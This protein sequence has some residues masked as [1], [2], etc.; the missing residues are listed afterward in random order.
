MNSEEKSRAEWE[1][2]LDQLRTETRA[3]LAA[4]RQRG[5][6]RLT[7]VAGV[8]TAVMVAVNVAPV[9]AS[10]L[11][12]QTSDIANRAVTTKKLANRSVKPAKLANNAVRTAKIQNGA[13]LASKIAAGAVGTGHLANGAVTGPKLANRSVSSEKIARVVPGIA[14][15]GADISAN[16]VSI[17]NWFNRVGGVPVVTKNSTGDYSIAFPG[18]ESQVGIDS[19]VQVTIVGSGGFG[20]QGA[21]GSGI[22]RVF[23]Y[24][25]TGT[26]TDKDFNVTVVAPNSAH[27]TPAST[28]GVDSRG[29]GD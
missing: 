6:R 28:P 5:R 2:R 13:V 21:G 24:G 26:L 17:H 11:N 10:H 4:E 15:A 27:V 9:A 22:I 7:L 18:L 23:T 14:V 25:T 29:R 3:A 12:V 1:E 16:G 20:A 19:I 8:L